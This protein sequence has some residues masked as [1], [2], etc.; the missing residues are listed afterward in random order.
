MAGSCY[1]AGDAN[2]KR[3]HIVLRYIL[4]RFRG[5][6]CDPLCRRA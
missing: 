5:C 6:C 4:V 1:L 2:G 3:L